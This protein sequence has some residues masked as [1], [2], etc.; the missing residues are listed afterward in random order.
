MT[1]RPN[2]NSVPSTVLDGQLHGHT[3][4]STRHRGAVKAI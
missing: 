3:Y 2:M 1:N 4:S